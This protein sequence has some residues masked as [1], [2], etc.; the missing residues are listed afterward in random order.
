MRKWLLDE[1][2]LVCV[3]GRRAATR[4]VLKAL[5]TVT[6]SLSGHSVSGADEEEQPVF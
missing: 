2:L 1:M 5:L 6:S 4:V 3:T